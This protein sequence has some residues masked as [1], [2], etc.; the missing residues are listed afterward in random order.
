ML[1]LKALIP[2]QLC[3]SSFDWQ[4]SRNNNIDNILWVLIILFQILTVVT[5][6]MILILTSK[7]QIVNTAIPSKISNSWVRDQLDKKR[8]SFWSLSYHYLFSQPFFPLAI[9]LVS[10][11]EPW[12]V[13]LSIVNNSLIA[14]SF[15][16]NTFVNL[17]LIVEEKFPR[18]IIQPIDMV[19]GCT[20]C[21]CPKITYTNWP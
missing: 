9:P 14:G 10:F 3:S 8:K 12:P 19:I 7:K 16:F 6:F 11:N 15:K 20:D 2:I 17:N 5:L 18:I 21:N 13:H 4:I 1:L